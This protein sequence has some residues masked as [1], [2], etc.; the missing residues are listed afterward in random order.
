MLR[1]YVLNEWL[2]KQCLPSG[3]SHLGREWAFKQNLQASS[4]PVFSPRLGWTAFQQTLESRQAYPLHLQP[5][6]LPGVPVG[7]SLAIKLQEAGKLPS[8]A[9]A[10]FLS[11]Q[12]VVSYHLSQR[13]W[14]SSPFVRSCH[15]FSLLTLYSFFPE[16]LWPWVVFQ[17]LTTMSK[18]RYK[19]PGAQLLWPH[20]MGNWTL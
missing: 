4:W 7:H 16:L 15:P 5:G 3:N 2:K 12:I 1:S 11:I 13:H 8:W 14:L 9:A 19:I 6:R 10:P 20:C 18:I 17:L